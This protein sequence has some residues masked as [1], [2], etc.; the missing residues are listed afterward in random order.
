MLRFLKNTVCLFAGC[1]ILLLSCTKPADGTR[2]IIQSNL[3]YEDNVNGRVPPPDNVIESV[4]FYYNEDVKLIRATVYDDTGA[5]AHLLKELNLTY[6]PD[7]I[8]VAT[9]LDTIGDVLYTIR[10]N[11]KKQVT[12]VALVDS[13]GLYIS[14]FNDRI[15]N[16]KILPGD[17]EYVNFIY[18]DNDNLLQYELKINGFILG[19]AV[20]EYDNE[21]VPEEFD[22]KFLTKEIKFIYI[23]GLDLMSKLGLN[24]GKSSKNK[25]IRRSDISA[26]TGQVVEL[27]HYGYIRNSTGDITKRN[28]RFSTDTLFYQ[29]KY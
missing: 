29:F 25:L 13:S 27:Y 4:N 26:Q 21:A 2:E 14:Y 10:F 12:S 19:R 28:I 17:N 20:L 5:S 15:S 16:I 24:L 23:G 22:S 7:R 6:F 3:V 11:N 8:A 18:D 1:S 9:Y